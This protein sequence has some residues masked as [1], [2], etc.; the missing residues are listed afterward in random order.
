MNA[1]KDD[2][3]HNLDAHAGFIEEAA[4]AGCALV[5]DLV[6]TAELDPEALQKAR[7]SGG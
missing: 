4:E 5:E 3:Q 7:T 1:L 2:L 6:I